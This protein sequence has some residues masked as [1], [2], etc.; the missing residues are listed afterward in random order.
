MSNDNR[1]LKRPIRFVVMGKVGFDTFS[2]ISW[3][4]FFDEAISAASSGIDHDDF[5]K[6]TEPTGVITDEF[7]STYRPIMREGGYDDRKYNIGIYYKYKSGT[8]NII[9]LLDGLK[10]CIPDFNV[11][12]KYDENSEYTEELEFEN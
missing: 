8:K 2:F 6:M 9:K 3:P 4:K 7:Y 10:S 5:I 11:K 1:V 12:F